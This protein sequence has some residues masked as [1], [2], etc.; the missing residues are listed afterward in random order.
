MYQ[1]EGGIV[2]YGEKYGDE[3]L[4][5]GSLYM[6]DDRMNHNFSDSPKVIGICVHCKGK[7]SNYE[8]CDD[9]SCN[10]LVLICQ[11]CV[12]SQNILCDSHAPQTV[13]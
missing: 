5:E 9:V 13:A 6:F 12:A 1:I 10:R 3:G 4:W 2:K 8:N 11:D 7:T